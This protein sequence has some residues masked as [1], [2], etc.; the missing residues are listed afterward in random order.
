RHDPALASDLRGELKRTISEE[1]FYRL[2]PSDNLQ[3]V[4]APILLQHGT[5]DESV[6]YDWSV[7]F[8]KKLVAAGIEHR[9]LT[10]QGQNHNLSRVQSAALAKDAE[11]FRENLKK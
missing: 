1:N 5:K 11:F 6:P 10:W 9:F 7:M 3:Y 2:S 8:E 4:K